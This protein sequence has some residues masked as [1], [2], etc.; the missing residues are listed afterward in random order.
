MAPQALIETI[1]PPHVLSPLVTFAKA[2]P[3]GI[4]S[5]GV[6]TTVF[7]FAVVSTVTPLTVFGTQVG[8]S[9]T[10]ERISGVVR[11]DTLVGVS[12]CV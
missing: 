8:C 12:I 3:V 6:T 7:A 2:G 4:E 1:G 5:T 10:I 9:V 11:D